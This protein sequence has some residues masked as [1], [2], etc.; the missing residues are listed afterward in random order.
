MSRQPCPHCLEIFGIDLAI[1]IAGHKSHAVVI[2]WKLPNREV[3]MSF[4]CQDSPNRS[5]TFR[6]WY[7]PVFISEQKK[8]RHAHHSQ[9]GDRV[10]VHFVLEPIETGM[11]RVAEFDGGL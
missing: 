10:V 4:F 2:V 9:S 6:D 7:Q 3:V 11:L 1:A 8:R 5:N